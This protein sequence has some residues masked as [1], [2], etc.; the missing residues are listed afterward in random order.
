MLKK[1][2][3]Q[4]PIR[5]C[6]KFCINTSYFCLK[7]KHHWKG[8]VQNILLYFV[9]FFTNFDLYNTTFK[10]LVSLIVRIWELFNDQLEINFLAN[11]YTCNGKLIF[12]FVET[13]SASLV[14]K[15]VF[16]LTHG[17]KT[18]SNKNLALM[19]HIFQ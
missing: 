12:C 5:K 7:T 14:E 17:N 9:I 16:F 6:T 18:S 8:N 13:S 15:T 2:V 10:S 1:C 11:I 19:W 4:V 3:R